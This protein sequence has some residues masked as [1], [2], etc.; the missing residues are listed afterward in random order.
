MPISMLSIR[1]GKL[2][3]GKGQVNYMAFFLSG[4]RMVAHCHDCR[5]RL[6]IDAMF[7]A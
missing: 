2:E 1:F 4:A 7:S 3:L 5:N 6:D